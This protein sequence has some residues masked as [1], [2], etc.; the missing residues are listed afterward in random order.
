MCR[1]VTAAPE[2]LW[3]VLELLQRNSL[4]SMRTHFGTQ[5]RETVFVARFYPEVA[6]RVGLPAGDFCSFVIFACGSSNAT[7]LFSGDRAFPG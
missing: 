7:G 6:I 2:T 4:N 5:A 3:I 1:L